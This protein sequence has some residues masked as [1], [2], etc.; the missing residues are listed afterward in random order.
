MISFWLCA[1]VCVQHRV[2]D[3]NVHD[4]RNRRESERRRVG[5]EVHVPGAARASAETLYRCLMPSHP[6]ETC[7]HW[8]CRADLCEVSSTL[9]TR[10][11]SVIFRVTDVGPDTSD[12][13]LSP[14]LTC[15]VDI[16]LLLRIDP[17]PT[18]PDVGSDTRDT[19]VG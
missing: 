5:G 10:F 11:I 9:K 19:L 14:R 6:S 2:I 3:R 17:R 7:H 12:T 13:S 1:C 16:S 4:A 18:F 15:R 8:A